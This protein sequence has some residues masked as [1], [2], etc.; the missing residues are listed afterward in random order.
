LT[1]NENQGSDRCNSRNSIV[2]WSKKKDGDVGR[3]A[4]DQA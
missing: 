3:Q 4:Q 2:G 1:G